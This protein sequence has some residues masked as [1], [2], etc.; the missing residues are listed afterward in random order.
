MATCTG[1]NCSSIPPIAQPQLTFYGSNGTVTNRIDG[2]GPGC[3]AT[4][5]FCYDGAGNL[6]NDG[7]MII[8]TYDAEGRIVSLNGE[9]YSY[10]A[11]G[12]RVAKYSGSTV[13]ASYLL[14]LSNNQVTEL[15]SAGTWMHSNLYAEG[16]LFATYEG[17]G[18]SAPN[19]CHFH[20]TDWLGTKRMQTTSAG[21]NEEQ[22]YS[23]PFGDALSCPGAADATEHH[24]TGKEHDSESGND[25]FGARYLSSILGRWMSPDPTGLALAEAENPQSLNL[26]SYVQ[27]N[28]LSVIDPDG[29]QVEP[30]ARCGWIRCKLWPQ[31]KNFFKGGGGGGGG[32]GG[33]GGG[34]NGGGWS[35]TPY[36]GKNLVNVEYPRAGFWIGGHTSVGIYDS[37]PTDTDYNDPHKAYGFTTVNQHWYVRTMLIVGW[38]FFKGY[39]E[40]DSK[41]PR[42]KKVVEYRYLSISDEGFYNAMDAIHHHSGYYRLWLLARNCANATEDVDHAAGA[43][44]VPHHEIF[45]P[46]LFWFLSSFASSK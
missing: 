43:H 13:M 26:Y 12:N 35:S 23:Y 46:H 28:P 20:L 32:N 30:A 40:E 38:P 15:N 34:G 19:T 25:Y 8:Y 24:F 9:T 45:W 6:L 14:D 42:S 29:L 2:P 16:R 44:R 11:E 1:N 27:N 33:G 18:E 7:R 17:P 41:S 21:V 22:C 36:P 4:Q 31:I 37:D 10:D 3:N 5:A 39:M